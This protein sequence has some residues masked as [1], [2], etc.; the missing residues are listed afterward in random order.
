[1]GH[2]SHETIWNEPF[3]FNF[4]HTIW[5]HTQQ[6]LNHHNNHF[7]RIHV[8]IIFK[9][10]MNG[11]LEKSVAV[12]TQTNNSF[13][14]FL[15]IVTTLIS[16]VREMYL[17]KPIEMNTYLLIYLAHK[18]LTHLIVLFFVTCIKFLKTNVMITLIRN[19]SHEADQKE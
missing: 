16:S 18:L 2:L 13:N 1:M 12:G 10:N 7:W 14:S 5:W 4:L 8:M 15:S 11:C 3:I 19:L 6:F 17:V 9:G